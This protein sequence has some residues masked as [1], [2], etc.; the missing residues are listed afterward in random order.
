MKNLFSTALLTFVT[1]AA[2]V[3]GLC[4]GG[5][6]WAAKVEPWLDKKLN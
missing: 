2:S 1:A 4:A 3:I 6:L 5:S